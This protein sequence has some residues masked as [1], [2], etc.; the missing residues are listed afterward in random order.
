MRTSGQRCLRLTG[1]EV[2]KDDASH[3]EYFKCDAVKAIR[4]AA[5][6]KKN[7]VDGTRLLVEELRHGA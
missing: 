3:I 1:D 2:P 4:E 5:H 6:R 7:G